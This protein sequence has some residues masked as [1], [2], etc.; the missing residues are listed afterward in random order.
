MARHFVTSFV[1]QGHSCLTWAAQAR[2]LASLV[3]PVPTHNRKARHHV[4]H[5]PLAQRALRSAPPPHRHASSVQLNST[6]RSRRRPAAPAL[7]GLT[8]TRRSQPAL[9]ASTHVPQVIRRSLKPRRL[10]FHRVRNCPA[11]RRYHSTPRGRPASAA[12]LTHLESTLSTARHARL[13]QCVQ[14]LRLRR[15]LARPHLL[16]A[17]PSAPL[18]LASGD[19]NLLCRRRHSLQASIFSQ[20][21]SLSIARFSLACPC[22]RWSCSH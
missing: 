12:Q 21:T 13:T 10:Q 18:S 2:P 22:L 15:W 6:P 19:S 9:L 4:R 20:A 1:L 16:P 7:L 17:R 5:A 8:R 3:P 14:V 11:K